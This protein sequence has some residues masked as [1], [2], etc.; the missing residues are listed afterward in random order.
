MFRIKILRIQGIFLGMERMFLRI[1]D[2]AG[3]PVRLM[4]WRRRLSGRVKDPPW[5][6][7]AGES[8]CCDGCDCCDSCCDC[9]CCCDITLIVTA[10]IL[11]IIV[12]IVTIIVIGVILIVTAVIVIVTVVIV[13]VVIHHYSS[14]T[15]LL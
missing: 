15:K 10:V 1:M 12:I 5:H 14:P 6:Y 3:L 13:T 7:T 11:E 8:G 4:G 2:L 9:D